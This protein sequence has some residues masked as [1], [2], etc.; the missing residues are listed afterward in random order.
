MSV[1]GTL[2]IQMSR[3]LLLL[4]ALVA[5]PAAAAFPLCEG[6]P[7]INCVVDGDTFWLDGEKIRIADIDAPERYGPRC[8]AEA[9]LSWTSSERL[10]K[11]LSSGEIVLQRMGEDRYGRA[12]A[13]VSVDGVDVGVT[14]MTEGLAR[15]WAGRRESW[16]GD[17]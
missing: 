5:Q 11:L 4:F 17:R 8:A 15:P 14:L 1:R 3:A 16:C 10:G 6:M 13:L 12:L 2:A 7:R 9:A